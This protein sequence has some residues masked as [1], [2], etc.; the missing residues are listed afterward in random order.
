L[1]FV[2]S[3]APAGGALF[4]GEDTMIHEEQ[5]MRLA[6]ARHIAPVLFVCK[7]VNWHLS[8][9]QALSDD[10][11]KAIEKAMPKEFMMRVADRLDVTKRN[12]I[13]EM[14]GPEGMASVYEMIATVLRSFP[15]AASST[16]PVAVAGG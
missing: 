12:K 6:L 10:E 3:L 5:L 11:E 1:I 8:N 7:H 15:R 9:A 14:L 4:T 16:S 13:A 2:A